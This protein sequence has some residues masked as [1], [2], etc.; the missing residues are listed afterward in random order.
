MTQVIIH[1]T[2]DP[3]AE[4]L[5]LEHEKIEI[6]RI[7]QGERKQLRNEL[8]NAESITLRY[9]P[10]DAEDL[11]AARALKL[12]TSLY[13]APTHNYRNLKN[14]FWKHFVMGNDR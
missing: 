5:L 1:E 6:V 14:K 12:V 9:L 13:I 4:A 3:A 10:L 2:V 11:R 7:A 8:P